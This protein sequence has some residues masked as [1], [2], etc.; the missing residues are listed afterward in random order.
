[1]KSRFA[2]GFV[3]LMAVS[4]CSVMSA[5]QSPAEL[6]A[7]VNGGGFLTE[8]TTT[9]VARNYAAVVASV[10][11]GAKKC[12]NRNVQHTSVSSPG[13]GMAPVRSVINMYYKTDVASKGNFT[14]VAMYKRMGAGGTDM[15]GNKREGFA[16]VA[17]IHPANGGAELK[18]YGGKFGYGPIN[19]AVAQWAKGGA[20][21]CPDLP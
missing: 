21:R 13:P 17:D 4:G 2:L 1:M 19:A 7:A 16:Y 9:K 8:A 15:F 20:I 6:R 3:T 5:P 14:E 10:R 12:M 11:A 18:F